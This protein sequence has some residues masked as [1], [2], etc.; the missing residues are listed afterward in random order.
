MAST[1]PPGSAST[2]SSPNR[3]AAKSPGRS[4]SQSDRI[5]PRSATPTKTRS[6]VKDFTDQIRH[7]EAEGSKLM[8]ATHNLG[9]ECQTS[10]LI[11]TT[12]SRTRAVAE[13]FLIVVR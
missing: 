8:A 6:T 10:N 2:N 12:C 5:T 1:Q 4:T 13:P 11:W 7:L 3:G 9:G